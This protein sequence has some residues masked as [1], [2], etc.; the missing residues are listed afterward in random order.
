MKMTTKSDAQIRHGEL[1]AFVSGTD[2]FV[3]IRRVKVKN[4]SKIIIGLIVAVLMLSTIA[5]FLPRASRPFFLS[6]HSYIICVLDSNYQ[7]LNGATN[8]VLYQSTSSSAAINYLLGPS[9]IA[10]NGNTIYVKSGAY[11]V[12]ATWNI[13][14]TGV[15]VTFQS[16]AILTATSNH[17][18]GNFGIYVTGNDVVIT[19]VTFDGNGLNQSPSPT[20]Y[21]GSNT[22]NQMYVGI[23]LAGNNDLVQHST[24]YNWRCYAIETSSNNDGATNNLIYNIGAN[25]ITADTSATKSYFSNNEVYGCGDVGIDSYGIDTQITG[26]YIHDLDSNSI[27]MYGY[28]NSYWGIGIENGGGS[29]NGNYLVIANNTVDN[30]SVGIIISQTNDSGTKHI[31]ISDNIVSNTLGTYS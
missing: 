31:L 18:A 19:G 23:G 17:N 24:I 8:T 21:V 20:T 4:K 25:G 2:I 26:N 9:G 28:V 16:G 13:A 3:L 11:T 30:T 6:T 12:D 7:V 29:G 14:V 15:T 5:M 27:T 1:A 22:Y 10:T